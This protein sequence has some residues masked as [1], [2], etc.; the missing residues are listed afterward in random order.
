MALKTGAT[1]LAKLA[2]CIEHSSE[3]EGSLSNCTHFSTFFFFPGAFFGAWADWLQ[4]SLPKKLGT[5]SLEMLTRFPHLGQEFNKFII[6]DSLTSN[7]W[8]FK[9][10]VYFCQKKKRLS[11]L[12]LPA[13]SYCILAINAYGLT[14]EHFSFSST[15]Q[16]QKSKLH[17]A[18]IRK[19]GWNL[20]AVSE[21]SSPLGNP[22]CS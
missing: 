17:R 8:S 7:S 10:R 5:T 11:C 4:Q 13:N 2:Y 22:S 21:I 20:Q 15:H 18:A 16:E 6:N 9:N 1:F 12:R 3:K 14:W 19:R